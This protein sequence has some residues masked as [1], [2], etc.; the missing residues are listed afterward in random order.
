M[1]KIIA[2]LTKWNGDIVVQEI[3]KFWANSIAD[4]VKGQYFF[5]DN[6]RH[7]QINGAEFSHV[8][9]YEVAV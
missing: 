5:A 1:T 3:N 4:A 2:K 7:F 9:V 8:E 6:K